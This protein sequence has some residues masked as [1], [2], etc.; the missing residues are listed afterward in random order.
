MTT[1]NDNAGATVLVVEDDD[2]QRAV[3][4]RNLHARGYNTAEAIDGRSAIERWSARRPDIVLL[5][6][7][8]PD[9]E[10]LRIVR[11]IRAEAATP[12]VILSARYDERQ[13]VEA[14]DAG[15][16][17]YLTKPFGVDELNARLRVALRHAAGRTPSEDARLS[18]GPLALDVERH[19]VTVDGRPIELTPREFEILRVLMTN[20]GRLV[21]KAKLLRA[22][23]GEQY[24]G[25]DGYI[26]VYVSQLRRKLAEADIHGR[27]N[28]LIVT[29]PGVGY[30]VRLPDES[31][32]QDQI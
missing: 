23:W 31:R 11:H 18:A 13:K 7:G 14:L 10:G 17:D 29:E 15:A 30:R 12:I 6:L 24:Q 19:E 9:V 25:E 32:G 16:D 4:V 1:R 22:V 21:T 27:L 3:L 5:D 20:P 28:H 2:E 8:L 26:Y